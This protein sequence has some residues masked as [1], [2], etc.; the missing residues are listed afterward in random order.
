[1]KPA[2]WMPR[3]WYNSN[4]SSPED[5]VRNEVEINAISAYLFANAEKHD[6]AVKNPPRG[7]AK[8][9]EQIVKSI[10]CQ[11]CHVVGE[12]AR[13]EAG[14]RRTFGQPL[15]NIGNKTSYE[16][17]YNWVRDPKHYS[18]ATYMPNLRLTDPQ[19]ADVATYLE[20]LKGPGGDAPK[21]TPDQ[22]DVD[23]VLLDYC[24][25]VMPFEDA[26]AGIAKLGPEQ[27]Q[28]ELGQRVISRYGCFSCH[29]IKGFEKAQSIGTDL[30]EEG[31][32]LV[33]RL[34]FAFITDIPHTSK[35]AW[36]RTKLHDPRIFDRGRVLKPEEKLRMPNFDFN[37]EEVDR[38]LIAL[39]SFQRE[40][41][42]PA[43]MPARSREIRLRRDRAYPRASAQ[44][45]RLPHHRGRRRRFREAA[46][47]S[48]AR[49]ADADAGGR[50]RAAG[51][52]VRLPA[53]SDHDPALARRPDADLRAGRPQPERRHQLLRCDIEH[54]GPVPDARKS[55]ASRTPTLSASNCS[56]LSSASSVTCS[57]RFRRISPRRTWRRTSGWR[58]IDCSLTGF[59]SG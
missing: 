42:P 2:T 45:R 11:G 19:V 53:W 34:D 21:A 58:P 46:C 48:V 55:C 20:S 37:D 43:A 54:R 8:N 1:M 23:N 39:M 38:L 40:I 30:S 52:A 16:W 47:G 29:D 51:L 35:T 28:I 6:F 59:W 33:T 9:G 3:F 24:K 15:E 49:S 31:S 50:A 17:I 44:L 36:F 13:A 10:G 25:A 4:N 5:A 14:P 7:N 12:G 57:E 41:Q 18:P 56:R 26:K 32:K 27:K 22:K